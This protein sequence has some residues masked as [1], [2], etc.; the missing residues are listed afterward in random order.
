VFCFVKPSLTPLSSLLSS[1]GKFILGELGYLTDALAKKAYC[2]CTPRQVV[3]SIEAPV[4]AIAVGKAHTAC[5]TQAGDIYLLGFG[6]PQ[7]RKLFLPTILPSAFAGYQ[8]AAGASSS[9]SP[10]RVLPTPVY[11]ISPSQTSFSVLSGD[12][13]SAPPTAAASRGHRLLTSLVA[14]GNMTLAVFNRRDV[15]LSDLYH[16]DGLHTRIP[17]PIY[18]PAI[19]GNNTIASAALNTNKE[20]VVVTGNQPPPHPLQH[21][22]QPE[23]GCDVISVFHLKFL[24]KQ[25]L[26]LSRLCTITFRLAHVYLLS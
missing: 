15:F 26:F 5:T 4:V 14:S 17:K 13:L 3:M 19:P 23:I 2:H 10:S 8:Q 18:I 22:H 6:S 1:I 25:I 11:S 16:V 20:I 24:M 9:S 7:A 21:Q 12:S